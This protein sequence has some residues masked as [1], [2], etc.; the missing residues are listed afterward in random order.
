MLNLKSYP[1]FNVQQE[2]EVVNGKVWSQDEIKNEPM[3]FSVDLNHAHLLGGPITHQFLAHVREWAKGEKVII[4]SRVHMLMRGW[5]PC[6]PGWHLDD[7][8]RSRPDGQPDHANPSYKAE[9]LMLCEGDA[10][11]THFAVGDATLEDVPIGG[12][13]VYGKWHYD[14]ERLIHDG[15]L[16]EIEV[17]N[18]EVVAFDWQ[19]FHR[20]MPATKS[21]WRFFIRATKNTTRPV[22]N[23]LRKQ[24]QVYLPEPNVGW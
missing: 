4:D 12:G 2:D 6:I 1:R 16:R 13:V 18:G 5:F 15:K 8:P 21:G 19:C 3:L 22:T 14:I 7:V 10:S 17:R 23:E 20:G 11:L 24:V 9:H